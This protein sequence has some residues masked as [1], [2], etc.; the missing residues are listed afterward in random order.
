MIGDPPDAMTLRSKLSFYRNKVQVLRT[1]AHHLPAAAVAP[2]PALAPEGLPE[3]ARF[4]SVA[5]C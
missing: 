1:Q 2:L 4:L 3:S 5:S